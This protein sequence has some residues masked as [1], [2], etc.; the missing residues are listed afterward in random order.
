MPNLGSCPLPSN[1]MAAIIA[2]A[3][4]PA[5]GSPRKFS[6][7]DFQN[8]KGNP[9]PLATLTGAKGGVQPH[10]GTDNIGLAGR[11]EVQ[12]VSVNA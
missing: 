10:G 8:P 9:S 7:A 1:T 12:R 5:P 6:T 4:S 2:I 11:Q 3:A